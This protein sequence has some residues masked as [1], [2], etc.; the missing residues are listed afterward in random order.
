MAP[1][2]FLSSRS[3]LSSL[4]IWG[5]SLLLLG[6]LATEVQSTMPLLGKIALA[7]LCLLLCGLLLWIWFGTFYR[8]TSSTLSYRSG[9]IHGQIPVQQI[10]EI[11]LNT[12]LWSGLRPAL[13]PKGLVVL[14]NKWDEIYLSPLDQETF[15]KTLLQLN[16]D[17]IIS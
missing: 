6:L 2:T 10:K 16:P 5:T 9:P 12:Y 8:I 15:L 7:L 11:R 14:Y 4:T 3:W 17:I 13:G 1:V